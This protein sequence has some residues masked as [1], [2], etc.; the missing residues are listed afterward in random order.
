MVFLVVTIGKYFEGKVLQKIER[1]TKQI[2]IESSLF[3]NMKASYVEI[4][5]RQL[6]V[7]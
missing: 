3:S 5:N 1:M 2:F 7:L 4:K 6:V